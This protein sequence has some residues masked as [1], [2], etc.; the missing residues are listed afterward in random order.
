M[1][2]DTLVRRGLLPGSDLAFGDAFEARGVTPGT[3]G[4]A[5]RGGCRSRP[6]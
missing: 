2:G 5:L 6:T 4:C 1:D 3:S